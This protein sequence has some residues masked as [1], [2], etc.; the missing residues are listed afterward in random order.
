MKNN[1]LKI[2]EMR[3]LGKIKKIIYKKIKIVSILLSI[4]F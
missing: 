1:F 2:R 3:I 4:I